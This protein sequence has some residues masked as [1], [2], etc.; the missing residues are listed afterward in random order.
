MIYI[1]SCD[2]EDQLKQ[3]VRVMI[4]MRDEA[5]KHTQPIV[6]DL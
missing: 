2:S 1:F 5:I 3:W 6:F 4:F